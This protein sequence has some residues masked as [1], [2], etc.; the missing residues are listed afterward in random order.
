MGGLESPTHLLAASPISVSLVRWLAMPLSSSRL[1]E[2][3]CQVGGSKGLHP[4]S[5]AMPHQAPRLNWIG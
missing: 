3:T 2:V 1:R 4:K 5:R